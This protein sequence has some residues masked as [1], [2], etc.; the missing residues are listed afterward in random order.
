MKG[1]ICLDIEAKYF[2]KIKTA[3]IRE[4]LSSRGGGIEITLVPWGYEGG[5]TAYQNYLGGGLLGRIQSD[6]NIDGWRTDMKLQ[7]IALYLR[8]YMHSLT[9]PDTEWEGMTYLQNTAMPVSGY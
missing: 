8:K 9:N 4:K 5:M 7:T 2:E 3:T 6:C 1:N